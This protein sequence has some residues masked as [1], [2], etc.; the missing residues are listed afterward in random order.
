MGSGF[1]Q[2]DPIAGVIESSLESQKAKRLHH[3]LNFIASH[4]GPEHRITNCSSAPSTTAIKP[5]RNSA[6]LSGFNFVSHEQ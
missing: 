1:S 4:I 6:G 5:I 3:E 2:F